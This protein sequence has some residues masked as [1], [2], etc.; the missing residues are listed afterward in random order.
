M[1]LVVLA[2]NTSM[3]RF[4]ELTQAPAKVIAIGKSRTVPAG[5]YAMQSLT[6]MRIYEQLNPKFVLAKDVR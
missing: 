4:E 2:A 3:V 5:K 6:Q 1:V